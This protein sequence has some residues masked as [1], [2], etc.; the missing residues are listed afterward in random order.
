MSKPRPIE[1]LAPARNADIA[2]EAIRHG[3][4][5]VYIGASSHGARSA[6]ANSVADISRVV[7]FAHQF[8]CRVYVTLNTLVYENEIH[9]V[10][11]LVN[12]LYH[13]GVDALIVQDMGILRMKLPPIALH[14]STQCDIRTP[15][16]ALFLANA[17][18]SQL[19]LPREMTIEEMKEI[20]QTVPDTPLE[21]FV[22]GALCVSYSGDC[23][24]G[25]ATARRSA[26][27]G[28][29][30]QICR[31]C[32]NLSD[33]SGNIL[34]Q[35]R[36]LLSLRD[37]NRSDLIGQ[38]LEAGISSFKI[39][40]R[41]KD[42]T[43]VKNTVAAYRLA[44]D[45]AISSYPGLYRRASIGDSEISFKTDLSESFNRGFTT[46][47]TTGNRPTEKM[48]SILSPKWT[49]KPVGKVTSCTPRQIRIET[50][51]KLA[52]GDGFGY[53]NRQNQFTGFRAN[54]ADGNTIVPA[55][56]QTIP[57]GTM[58]YRNH[59]RLREEALAGNTARR[60]IAVDLTLST[61]PFG[62][63]LKVS[64]NN[65]NMVSLSE[66]FE[67]SEA[68][69]P[70]TDSRRELLSKTGDTIYTVKNVIDKADNLFIPRSLLAALRR[71]VLEKMTETIV[72]THPFDYRR[73]E[74]PANPVTWTDHL[75]YH[76]NVA[77]SLSRRFYNDHGI[78]SIEPAIETSNRK[79]PE[80]R[81]MTTRYCLRR[82]CDRCLRTPDGLLWRGPLFLESGPDR[83]RLD[84]DCNE[85][86]MHVI[87]ISRKEKY[88]DPES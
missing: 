56:P 20:H 53:F 69:N 36:H 24:A 45:N 59:N 27:R 48:A 3:A 8:R 22:H 62:F 86:R 9:Q 60:S 11:T 2:I 52:N 64:D 29:C 28:E 16:K 46:Y 5:A 80:T 10:E 30:P 65:G 84:F 51:C 67:L 42:E 17:G 58:L 82:E 33:A 88:P 31:H 75:D 49:G 1:L 39:E 34:I 35:K 18:F 38:M 25:F 44:I 50:G 66:P 7:E 55:T 23:Q 32:F 37:L 72:A 77:N 57:V 83:F 76:D 12:E 15:E 13:A 63:A 6:A 40:G 87:H 26:N 14:A 85:C 54:R 41:L 79:C 21:A 47:F 4:D 81:V 61:T 71:R 74:Q 68:K 78:V 70:Q 19:V 43:Y 73:P